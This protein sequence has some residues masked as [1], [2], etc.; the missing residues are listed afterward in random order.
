MQ[1]SKLHDS[2]TKTIATE[3]CVEAWFDMSGESVL[4]ISL[5]IDL[6]IF[7]AIVHFIVH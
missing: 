4:D 5:G 1:V 2:L 6:P 3:E 7:K